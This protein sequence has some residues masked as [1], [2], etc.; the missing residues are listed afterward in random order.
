[1]SGFIHLLGADAPARFDHADHFNPKGYWESKAIREFNDRV[2]ERAGSDWKDWDK[3]A[4]V[5]SNEEEIELADI[6]AKEY[7]GSRLFVI[8]DP[9]L[10]RFASFLLAALK[11]QSIEP[12]IVIP[13]RNPLEAALSLFERDQMPLEEGL[14]LW[15]RH[16]LDAEKVSR[17]HRRCFISFD[18][19][20]TDWRGVAQHIAA[21]LSVRWPE[22]SVN[23]I[24]GRRFPDPR[25]ASPP[26]SR[27]GA[28]NPCEYRMGVRHS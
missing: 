19:L 21:T 27:S 3:S 22:R 14:L 24:D 18:H 12:R 6:I 26:R 11:R 2:L 17:D 4:A 7:G 25:A 5:I 8:K 15:L 13:V 28:R 16:M 20:L 23:R 9:R 1:L 10:C